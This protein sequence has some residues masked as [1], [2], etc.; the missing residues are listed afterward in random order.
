MKKPVGAKN[1]ER[2]IAEWAANADPK[3]MYEDTKALVEKTGIGRGKLL[4]A[5]AILL[6]TPKI[7]RLSGGNST[8]I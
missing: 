4:K 8:N 1:V 6:K 7:A 5:E 2:I 3:N